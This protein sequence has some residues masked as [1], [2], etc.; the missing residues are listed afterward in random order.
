[1]SSLPDQKRGDPELNIGD[2]QEFEKIW[3][4]VEVTVWLFLCCFLVCAG[5]G[6]LGRGPLSSSGASSPDGLMAI[7]F[8]RVTRYKTPSRM[9]VNISQALTHEGAVSLWVSN[10]LL[11]QMGM[12]RVIPQPDHSLPDERGVTYIWS[13][14]SGH[15][16]V[17]V[18]FDLQPEAPGISRETLRVDDAHQLTI[19]S[20]VLP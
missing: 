15:R 2:D 4:R 1:M 16:G 20:I 14:D 18:A 17:Q 13:K 9:E 7:H 6:L 3:W 10:D 19:R 8:E 5:T 12:Q 11:K